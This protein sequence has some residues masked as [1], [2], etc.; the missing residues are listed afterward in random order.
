[1]L[2][3]YTKYI[4]NYRNLSMFLRKVKDKSSKFKAMKFSLEK[5]SEIQKLKIKLL[6]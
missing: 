4:K 6:L 1:M 3:K 2:K 5:K